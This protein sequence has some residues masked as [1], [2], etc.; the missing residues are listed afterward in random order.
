MSEKKNT[1]PG[2]PWDGCCGQCVHPDECE[3]LR[4]KAKKPLICRACEGITKASETG[5]M[6]FC[7]ECGKDW[8][9]K[10]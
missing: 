2:R 7:P 6:P 5:G 4:L 1:V 3:A 9:L 10:E 8:D